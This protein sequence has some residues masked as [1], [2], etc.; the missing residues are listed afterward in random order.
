MRVGGLLI[1]GR[2]ECRRTVGSI[3]LVPVPL[4]LHFVIVLEQ[5]QGC[6]K[7]TT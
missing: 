6:S 3:Y 7:A 1:I 5:V 2:Y 4:L